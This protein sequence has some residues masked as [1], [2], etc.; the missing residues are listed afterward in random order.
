MSCHEKG[1]CGLGDRGIRP[2]DNQNHQEG[3]NI[4][5][6]HLNEIFDEVRAMITLTF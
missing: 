6:V 4:T 1:V 5:T 2:H 3:V